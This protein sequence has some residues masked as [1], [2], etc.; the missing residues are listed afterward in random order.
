MKDIK[1]YTNANAKTQPRGC[2]LGTQSESTGYVNNFLCYFLKESQ[3]RQSRCNIK[4]ELTELSNVSIYIV[5]H[6]AYSHETN[7]KSCMS[8]RPNMQGFAERRDRR[9]ILHSRVP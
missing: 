5:R 8:G 3:R 4:Y 7:E 9:E 6:I 2:R 1:N